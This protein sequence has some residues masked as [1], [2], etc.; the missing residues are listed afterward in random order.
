MKNPDT[1]PAHRARFPYWKMGRQTAT[2][3]FGKFA[4]ARTTL[5]DVL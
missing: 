3:F 4:G 1:H 5:E 2:R